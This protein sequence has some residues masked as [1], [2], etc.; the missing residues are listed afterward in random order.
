MS[1]TA[2]EQLS[3]ADLMSVVTRDRFVKEQLTG[4]VAN[5][6]QENL[7]LLALVQQLQREV[8]QLRQSSVDP[9]LNGPVDELPHEAT[10]PN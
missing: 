4:R 5:L 6:V 2:L 7:E 1:E 10:V 9:R 8:Q 3:H